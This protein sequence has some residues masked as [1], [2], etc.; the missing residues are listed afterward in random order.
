MSTTGTK[1]TIYANASLIGFTQITSGTF[2]ETSS[3]S[4]SFKPHWTNP[5]LT[6]EASGDDD[7]ILKLSGYTPQ[8]IPNFGAAD[9]IVSSIVITTGPCANIILIGDIT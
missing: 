5:V 1:D 6:I 2:Y 7:Y 3:V 9:R 4:V 8:A